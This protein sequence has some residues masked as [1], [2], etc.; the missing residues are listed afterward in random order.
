MRIQIT[1]S[2]T[3]EGLGI[4][5][6]EPE[7]SATTGEASRGSP[8]NTRSEGTAGSPPNPAGPTTEGTSSSNTAEQ[9]DR[10]RE[11]ARAVEPAGAIPIPPQF[12][13]ISVENDEATRT[14]GTSGEPADVIPA[15]PEFANS[16]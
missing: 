14:G 10:S 4:D 5:I 16:E 3:G 12:R 15:P 8:T 1:I 13:D 11:A 7:Q 2:D 9:V 6:D